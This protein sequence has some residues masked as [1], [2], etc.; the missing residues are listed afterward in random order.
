MRENQ[1]IMGA[2][3][4]RMIER[5]VGVGFWQSCMPLCLDFRTCFDSFWSSYKQQ[6]CV[7]K[8]AYKYFCTVMSCQ[9][10]ILLCIK[11]LCEA[12][13]GQPRMRAHL[14]GE[15][16]TAALSGSG[17]KSLIAFPKEIKS[18]KCKP[19]VMYVRQNAA[20]PVMS[21]KYYS[22]S[23][24]APFRPHLGMSQRWKKHVHFG[25]LPHTTIQQLS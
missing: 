22:S 4:A 6:F 2:G 19:Y 5:W 15:Y 13:W 20:S 1:S 9:G 25:K 23:S 3:P 14:T 12:S 18:W 21:Q 10:W 16:S 24:D 11:I 17:Y 7:D 8:R